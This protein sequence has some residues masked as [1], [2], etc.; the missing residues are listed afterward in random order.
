ML[1][2]ISRAAK[3]L[4]QYT[5]SVRRIDQL[6]EIELCR[7]ATTTEELISAL[8]ADLT[9]MAAD[10]GKSLAVTNEVPPAVISA[11]ASIL[12]RVLENIVGNAGRA[13]EEKIEL[14]FAMCEGRLAVTV[15]DDGD[16]FPE[17]IL[18]GKN[19][20]LLPKADEGGHCGIG[21]TV[22]RILCRKHGGS[23]E[24]SNRVPHGAAVKIFFEV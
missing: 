20:L 23:I 15:A 21:L 4:E 2:N 18:S 17:E 8:T 1:G 6:D 7:R 12:H 11:D 19:R 16:G 9:V 24:L 14:S 3:R 10:A 5:E 22:S 13:A